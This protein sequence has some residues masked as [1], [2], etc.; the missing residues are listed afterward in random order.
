LIDASLRY[1]LL[2]AALTSLAG[3]SLLAATNGKSLHAALATFLITGLV[4]FLLI[5]AP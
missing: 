5:A 4:I 3:L 2:L 1:Y